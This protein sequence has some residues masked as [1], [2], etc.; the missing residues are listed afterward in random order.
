MKSRA[1]ASVKERVRE[2]ARSGT[3]ARST[4]ESRRNERIQMHERHKGANKEETEN[5]TEQSSEYEFQTPEMQFL[6]SPTPTFINEE[7]EVL[8]Q[9]MDSEIEENFGD[10]KEEI[11]EA[12]KMAIYE[13]NLRIDINR[14]RGESL[15]LPPEDDDEWL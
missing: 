6:P 7:S 11:D 5:E 2:T 9:Q 3:C 10:N 1:R 15:P 13:Y 12:R 8:E 4:S 14:S